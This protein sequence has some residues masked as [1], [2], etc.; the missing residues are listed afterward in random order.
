LQA[1]AVTVEEESAPPAISP[2]EEQMSR[3]FS[4]GKNP[5]AMANIQVRMQKLREFLA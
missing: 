3:V 2:I 4:F 5:T 1:P